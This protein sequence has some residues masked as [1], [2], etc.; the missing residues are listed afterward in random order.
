MS[1]ARSV[2]LVGRPNVGKSRLFNRLVGRRVS[3]VHDQPGVTR[4]LVTAMVPA[5]D[6][7]YLLMDTGGMAPP[8]GAAPAAI[9]E[10]VEEQ[11]DFA[12]QAASLV[13]FVTDARAGLT[14]ADEGIAERLRAFHKPTLLVVNKADHEAQQNAVG[15]FYRLGFGEPLGIS[16][17]HGRGMDALSKRIL[18]VVGP[19]PAVEAPAE[20]S[21]A[22]ADPSTVR[23]KFALVGRPNVGKSSIGNALLKS[24]RLIVNETPGTTRD[25][26]AIDLDY[27]T[28]NGEMW[29]FTLL[30][31]AG[32]RAATR[33]NASV[34]YFSQNRSRQ[35]IDECDVGVL[36]LDALSGV[37]KQD[38][39][40][41]GEILRG[42]AALV[43]VVNKWD[44]ARKKFESDP[45]PGYK[46]EAAFKK[47]FME[48]VHKELFFLPRSPV[49]FTSALEG[50]AVTEILQEV[51]R[52]HETSL[53]Q[54]PTSPLNRFLREHLEANPP[55]FVQGRR[56]KC[57]YALQVAR[58][59][60]V[61]RMYCNH[62][63]KLDER[64]TRYLVAGV[65]EAFKLQGCPIRFD[66][67]GKPKR[68]GGLRH[69]SRK[70][71][72]DRPQLAAGLPPAAE[73]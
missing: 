64:Y 22:A 18:E 41:A 40:L 16:A 32:L 43:I 3:I 8:P 21:M 19:A 26:I 28:P 71:G 36:V 69:G 33:V 13:I 31:T 57:Y 67:V 63:G 23:A 14:T 25:A 5:E 61:I 7:G 54:L 35:A 59:P 55:N 52:L 49:L 58:R 53:R 70:K 65:T 34:E 72:V 37:T 29:P 15:E 17:E 47:A 48:A 20:G 51:R 2:A 56:F 39:F 50:T 12:I 73:D 24:K 44:I 45:L 38:K 6:G 66:L 10:A 27:T 1:L 4:D 11:V 68:E 30:D 62:A 60:F 42:G 46:N 9:I